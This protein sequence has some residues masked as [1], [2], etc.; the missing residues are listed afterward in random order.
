MPSSVFF[1]K[2]DTAIL[3]SRRRPPPTYPHT[4]GPILDPENLKKPISPWSGEVASTLYPSL[5]PNAL[6]STV[7]KKPP[8]FEDRYPRAILAHNER[9][10]LPMLWY[11]TRDVLKEEEL[12]SG[13]QDKVHLAKETTGWE[14]AII[15]ILDIDVYIRLATV[16]VQLGILP[17]GET[18]CAHTVTQPPD[19]VFHLPTLMEDWRFWTCP[20]LEKGGLYAYAGVPLR[21]QHETGECVGLGSLCVA[22]SKSE[23]PLTKD[24]QQALVRLGD[25][26]VS[27]LL[28]A[29]RAKRQR[30][31]HRMAELLSN[32]QLELEKLVSEEP[33]Y[34]ILRSTYPNAIVKLQPTK[35]TYVELEGRKPILMSDLEGGL[36][37]DAEYLDALIS[38]SNHDALPTTHIVRILALAC[39]SVTGSSLLMVASKD[40]RL[41]F[42]DVDFWF[43]ETCAGLISQM[44]RKR[45]LL[46]ALRAKEKFLSGFSHQL[47]TPI[48]GILGSA[49]LLAEEIQSW[50]A[51]EDAQLAPGSVEQPLK[52]RLDEHSKYLGII[53]MG[54]RDLVAIINNMITTN[55]WADIAT[56]DRH[57]AMHS[58]EKLETELCTGLVNLTVGDTRYRASVFFTHD[59]PYVCESIWIDIDVLRDTI[60]PLI[61]NA[62]QHTPDGIVSV[63]LSLNL[64]SRQLTVDVKDNGQGIHQTD[65][66]RIFEPFEKVD[67]HST[68]AGLGLTVASR[69]ASL[70]QGSVAL[71]SS[72]FRRGSHFRATFRGVEY[73]SSPNAP[74]LLASKLQNLP[75]I[76]FNLIS[77]LSS[78]SLCGH[79]VTFLTRSGF[80]P[81]AC[82]EG[83]FIIFEAAPSLEQHQLQLSQIPSGGVAICLL[84]G[85]EADL[86][87]GRTA[88]NIVYVSGPF[89]TLS[90]GS[91]LEEADCL[92]GKIR[93]LQPYVA[94]PTLL[95]A[96]QA[97]EQRELEPNQLSIDAASPRSETTL[98]LG[99]DQDVAP[100]ADLTKPIPISRQLRQSSRPTTLIVDDNTI[101]LRIMEMY[102]K[103]RSLPYLA[104]KNGL[105]AVEIFSQ[106]QSTCIA[107]DEPPIELIFMDLQMPVCDGIEATRQIRSLEEQNNWGKVLI[108]VMTG[109]DTA[110]DKSAAQEAGGDKY[111]VKP[112]IIEQLDR[113]VRQCFP[114]FESGKKT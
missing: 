32:A 74:K 101:N 45:L 42:D 68:R 112:V 95:K 109:Q 93:S 99:S 102:C 67:M 40:F 25:C 103:K 27:D 84:P 61:M 21:L 47:R 30:D 63:T 80:A 17:R 5:D 59:L 6:T 54:G 10:R 107:N 34:Q 69:F 92:V 35:T 82:P 26:V 28:H 77:D 71:M 8:G 14:F 37:E 4:V 105:Q 90:L 83:S 12:L 76:F 88:K 9:L 111:L 94:L 106:R 66:Q 50:C 58:V 49:D 81:S 20:Y 43:V 91:A 18:I 96:A 23:E 78:M 53:K 55:R 19:S 97:P 39:E 31:R 33:I 73:A 57:Y 79:F 22:S 48:H 29:V 16:G 41:V 51:G 62:V 75:S 64:G 24:Q 46:E 38:E 85:L 56:M 70:L 36:W 87:L 113:I 65:Q 108:L 110:A 114:F 11:Y 1:P 89:S 7:C 3:S 72:K 15:G 44:W 60:L 104:A 86:P 13:L 100:S 52:I 98:S 2:A